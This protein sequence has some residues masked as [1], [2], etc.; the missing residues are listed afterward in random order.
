MVTLTTIFMDSLV[1]QTEDNL[2]SNHNSEDLVTCTKIPYATLRY[3]NILS[4]S[5]ANL[6][7]EHVF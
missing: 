6:L 7:S 3:H 5:C 1:S 2:L 4:F